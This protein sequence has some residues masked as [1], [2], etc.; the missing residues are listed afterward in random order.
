MSLQKRLLLLTFLESFATI[1]LER[2]IYFY[3]ENRLDFSRSMNLYLALI[4]GVFYV[5][6]ALL[7]H[8]LANRVSERRVLI[9]SIGAHLLL[10]AAMLFWINTPLLFAAMAVAAALNGLKWPVVE[11]YITAGRSSRDQLKIIGQFN[12]AWASAVPLSLLVVGPI[13][14]SSWPQ[15]LFLLAV[16]VNAVSVMLALAA[17]KRPAHL[18]HDH[19]DRP[20][21]ATLQRYRVLLSSSR[22]S[23]LASYSLLFLL[24]PML[25]Q[26]F[27]RFEVGIIVAPAASA[28]IDFVRLGSFAFL[29]R[30]HG[31]YGRTWPMWFCAIGRP[32][33]AGM[34]LFAQSLALMLIGEV[35]FGFCCGLTYYAALYYVVAYKNAAVDAGGTHEGLIGGGFAFGP[36]A[37]LIGLALANHIGYAMGMTIGIA[38]LILLSIFGG[39]LPL[40]KLARTQPA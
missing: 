29:Q 35:I 2:G 13:I 14:G 8:P 4:F 1:L 36:A 31:W 34:T 20:S 27:K 12:I 19:P 24:A 38:P 33:S 6:A 22:W 18:A 3:S 21:Q 25:P 15:G 10:H 28:L 23:M 39:L 5:A 32:I 16:G 26:I 30:W 40:R 7:C 11:S 9:G 37:G 17:P